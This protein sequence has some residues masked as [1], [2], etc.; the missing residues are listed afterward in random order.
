MLYS[1]VWKVAPAGVRAQA[2]NPGGNLIDDFFII[3]G[4][5][6]LHVCNAP[7]PAATASL[8]IGEY[9]VGQLKDLVDGLRIVLDSPRPPRV[10]LSSADRRFWA[11]ARAIHN[12]A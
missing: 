3:R 1:G 5:R 12:Q 8:K 4:T 6:T 2:L 7:S 11:D 9:I 10:P